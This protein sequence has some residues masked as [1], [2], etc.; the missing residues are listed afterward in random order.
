MHIG[1]GGRYRIDRLIAGGG[2]GLVHQGYDRTLHRVVAIKELNVNQTTD[3]E[4]AERFRQEARALAGMVHSNI[5]PVYDL[6]ED[7]N[8][9]WIVM[10]LLSGGD[11][12]QY[13]Q[14]NAADVAEAVRVIRA[15]AE[16]LA[17]AHG[18]GI[19]HRDIK[20]MNILFNSD[21]VP[22][23]VDFGI[24]KLVQVQQSTIMTQEGMSL[25]SPTYMS[26]EQ[27]I[28]SKDID[29]RADIYALGVTFY[30]L[31]TGQP[32]FT[33]DA[34]E[35]MLQHL[36]ATPPALQALNPAV[37]AALEAVVLKMM[38]KQREARYQSMEDVIKAL[39]G[40]KAA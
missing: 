27:A 16:G 33:G 14:T 35:V 17:Y 28:G 12:D 2:M 5:V 22:K 38:A 8:R 20:P 10:E 31:L 39:D 7:R 1:Q 34:Q 6:L 11:L 15:V 18:K 24:A 36:N 25:G 40:L 30:K 29:A 13:I 4:Q 23:L 19:V 32:P 37:D 26:P 3:A 21:R 9:F